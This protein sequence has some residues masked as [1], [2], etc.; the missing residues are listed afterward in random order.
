MN[1][2]KAPGEGTAAAQAPAMAPKGALF[3]QWSLDNQD[4]LQRRWEAYISEM[5]D[6][7]DHIRHLFNSDKC[8][9]EW[10]LK[11]YEAGAL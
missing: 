1:K 2:S 3:E 7:P 11:I 9:E 8:R 5:Q 6:S 4:S 10:E